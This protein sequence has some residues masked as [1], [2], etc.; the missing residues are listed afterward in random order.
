MLTKGVY[1]KKLFVGLFLFAF[2]FVNFGFSSGPKVLKVKGFYLGMSSQEACDEIHK[3][4]GTPNCRIEQSP[5]KEE[6][7]IMSSFSNSVTSGSTLAVF[8]N[9]NSLRVTHILIPLTY[10]GADRIILREFTEQFVIKYNIPGMEARFNS[11]GQLCYL[12]K[13]PNGYAVLIGSEPIIPWS[14]QELVTITEIPKT[15]NLNFN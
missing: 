8:F 4:T 6:E 9:K 12:Y 15:N 7:S 10:F 2:A 1:L 5:L 14:N 13:D 3:L 11:E